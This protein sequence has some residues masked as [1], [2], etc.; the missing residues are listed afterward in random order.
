MNCLRFAGENNHRIYILLPL[1]ILAA[2]FNASA[3]DI[4]IAW[5]ANTEADLAGY[6]IYYGTASR[7]YSTSEDVG[8][9]TS[10]TIENLDEGVTYY[11]AAKAYDSSQN[12]SGYSAE[13][14]H[15]ISLPNRSPDIP[16]EPS[17][18][19]SGYPNTAYGFSTA[20]SD[21]DGDALQYRF[22][23]G[24]GST[25]SW[26][27][28]SRT[29]S[30]SSTGTFCVKAQALDAHSAVSD[31]SA[32]LNINIAEQVH[33][34]TASA[35][36]NGRIVP[37][38]SLTVPRG[39]DQ[40][41]SIQP[42]PNYHVSNVLVDNNPLGAADTYTF[43][44]VTQ[45]H[46][47]RVQ[48]AGDNQLPVSQ[49]GTDQ[50]VFVNTTVQ[51]DGSGSSDADG[52]SLTYNWSFVAKPGGSSAALSN[53]KVV[54]PTFDVDV[55]GT[56]RLQ[57]IVNDGTVNSAPDTV[58]ISTEN[59]APV[60][61]AGADQTV[62]VNDMVPLDG[63]GS[64][65]VD[66]N[67]L[68]F[69][70]SLVAK[71]G[72]S[73]AALSD[74]H[75]V[76]PTF[77]VDVAGSYTVQ[78]IVN[79][80]T[81]NSA[82]DTVTISTENSA[83][84]SAAGADQA[85]LVNDTVQLDGSGSSDVD[86][87]SLTYAWSWVAK[88]AASQAALSDD[89]AAKPTFEV[90]GVGSYTLRLIVNDGTVN[91]APDTVT[92]STENSAPLSDAGADQTV[93]VNDTVQLDGGGSID[94]DG[95]ALTFAWS[96]VAKPQTSQAALS[97]SQAVK[98]VFEVD[99]AGTYTVQLIVN[100][101]TVNSP[102]DTVTI[103]TDNSAPVG[104]AGADQSVMVNDTVQLDGSGSSDVDGDS[105]TF[106]W[107]LVSK[108]QTSQAALSDAQA[109]KPTFEVD[110][111]GSYTIQ[112]IVNDGTVNSA[113]DTVTVS[114]DNSA[115]VSDAGADQAIRVND[116]VLLDG[117]GSRDV[118][119]SSLTFAWSFVAKPGGSQ[120]ALS[121]AQAV[122][123]AF[124]VDVA[125]TYTVQ[126]IV[127]DGTVNSAPDTVT[128][129]TEN[130]AP[131]SD[132]GVDQA[133]AVNDTVQLDGS[134]SRDAD[135]DSL[136]FKWSF[137][138]KPG[139]S[140]AALSGVSVVK[141]TFEVDVAG[142]YTV[143]LIVN[144]G[145]DDSPPDT[146]TILTE[147]SAPVGHA[148][149]NQTAA[150]GDLVT[151]SG[152]NSSDPDDNIAGYSWIQIGGTAV[153]L[154]NPQGPETTFTAPTAVTDADT[155][156]FRL[157][158]KDTQ[159]LQATD[160]CVVT[161]TRV[162]GVDSDGDGVPDD[163]DDFPY[164]PAESVDTDGDGE[165]NNA[166]TDD[167]NDGMPDS[168]EIANGLNPLEDDAAADPDQDQVSNINE[169]N[170]GTKPNYY[171]G[172][173]EP[174]APALLMPDNKAMVALTPELET[175]EFEDPN[176]NDVHGKTRWRITRAF[177]NLCVFDVTTSASLKSIA[178]P[179]QVLEAD[180]EYV[181]KARHFDNHDTPSQWSQEREFVTVDAARDLD[182]NG[183]P[184]DQEVS[185]FSDLDGDG[186][187]DTGQS[188]LRCV[189]VL[190]GKAEICIGIQGAPDSGSIVS[191]EA[192]DPADAQLETR[193]KGKPNYIEFE[194]IHFKLNVGEPG[195]ETT[196]TIYL[197]KPA[198][199]DGKCYKFDPV[200]GVWVDYSG[201][202][203]FSANR[204]QVYITIK[205]GGFGDADGI[206]NGIIVDPLAFGSATDPSG[207]S[208]SGSPLDK[209]FDGIIP[210]DFSCFI[211]AIAGEYGR[212]KLNAAGPVHPGF[213]LGAIFLVFV[214]IY[215][216][217]DYLNPSAKSANPDLNKPKPAAG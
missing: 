28:S 175:G 164:D 90:D 53:T 197:S 202:A 94:A 146:V 208:N 132:A 185:D 87:N 107:S 120:A 77:D 216:F 70:W 157:T 89:G 4:T 92:I 27:A 74:T 127:N 66:G 139:G 71:P 193:S 45:N 15:T 22:A 181:W 158:V 10:Y 80:G 67:S 86:G 81:V 131:V 38:G 112:L 17:G 137:V 171:E 150:E 169:Y 85:V 58:T 26:G 129:S 124:D 79:D 47:I 184:D 36:S 102:A 78:L 212:Y 73:H 148:G 8:D 96:I 69:A 172:N 152:L 21:P 145:T 200:E 13:L 35:D 56:Y 168:W 100:D 138:A 119:G 14:V 140:Q 190:G 16:Q 156:T 48:F 43:Y 61:N 106:A 174:E 46:S 196:A 191:L 51:L 192:E 151:L 63:S 101:G 118:D 2:A 99:V 68:T 204:K 75:A 153:V 163:Q 161:V 136:T 154:S 182:G 83:P 25:S 39:S 97:D 125:G 109:V 134:G 37:A 60:S 165:G 206:E 103:A 188:D 49:A 147:N 186:T 179:K 117:S 6:K 203:E 122:K 104:A 12:E 209:L 128:V 82:P 173:F 5:D 162:A 1:L 133:A 34:I 211:G 84:V 217:K 214:L 187:P 194:L 50:S 30:W 183:V 62:R 31:W 91:S 177:D 159:G 65:D 3:A 115:P 52:N 24:D 198:F 207:G 20:G 55:A 18:A 123:P 166:D 95:D 144:D 121:D 54:K 113:P 44:N 23:W 108:P 11:F 42:D 135:G 116:T 143:Q 105:L 160:D 205:D 9:T 33:T 64:S 201:S 167:D 114:T 141:P 149:D 210:N 41:F 110:V 189:N 72:A 57:L 142:S 98:P 126:L 170:L 7:N 19:T 130:S 76:K 213:V 111:A 180:T 59:S 195:G 32:C 178:V 176:I 40:T 93:R 199:K 215:V 155:L 88:P 29:H